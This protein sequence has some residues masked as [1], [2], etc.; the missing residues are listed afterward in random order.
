MKI[1]Y[2][3]PLPVLQRHSAVGRSSIWKSIRSAFV[4]GFHIVRPPVRIGKLWNTEIHI[5][6]YYEIH[7]KTHIS[8]LRT[9]FVLS[10]QNSFNTLEFIVAS[11]PG[12]FMVSRFCAKHTSFT[13]GKQRVNVV[14]FWSWLE[15]WTEERKLSTLCLHV[16]HRGWIS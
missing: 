1:C 12:S 5:G 13:P 2:V 6:A 15:V 10:E 8:L 11:A 14:F 7:S 3:R 16:F 9:Y 4:T